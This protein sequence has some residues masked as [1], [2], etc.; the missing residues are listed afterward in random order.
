MT[1]HADTLSANEI[2]F[3]TAN[4]EVHQVV[5]NSTDQ[6]GLFASVAPRRRQRVLVSHDD[7]D[8]ARVRIACEVENAVNAILDHQ[9]LDL[10]GLHCEIGR[11]KGT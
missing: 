9:R 6:V 7:V 10:I 11:R 1:I 4:L 2:L 3:C 5:V 8:V